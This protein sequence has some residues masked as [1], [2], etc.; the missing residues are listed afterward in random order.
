MK[1]RQNK[2]S[3]LY[4]PGLGTVPRGKVLTVDKKRGEELIAQGFEEVLEKRTKKPK[5]GEDKEIEK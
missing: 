3:E 2:M 4:I 1:V 5:V